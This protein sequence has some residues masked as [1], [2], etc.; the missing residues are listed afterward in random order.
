[1]PVNNRLFV[2]SQ[3]THYA[4]RIVHSVDFKSAQNI[5]QCRSWLS[6]SG[7]ICFPFLEVKQQH[8]VYQVVAKGGQQ[9]KSQ[10][11]W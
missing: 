4:E 2:C 5:Q 1:M 9:R 6:I 8:S 10:Q 11:W 3:A 7:R